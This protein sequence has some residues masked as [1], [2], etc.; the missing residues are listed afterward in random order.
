MNQASLHN[1]RM[2]T[3]LEDITACIR[4]LTHRGTEVLSARTGCCLKPLIEVS[5][6]PRGI[7]GI[8][9]T[10]RT[11]GEGRV[12]TREAEHMQCSISW[13]EST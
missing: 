13:R 4:D 8:P 7:E 6:A 9:E 5:H 1:A 2:I 3:Q 12:T 11:T 10:K